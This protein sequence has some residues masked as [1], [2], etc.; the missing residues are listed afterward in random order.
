MKNLKRQN[1]HV[2][3]EEEWDDRGHSPLDSD[4]RSHV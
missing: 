1:P 3:Q 2:K 4:Y